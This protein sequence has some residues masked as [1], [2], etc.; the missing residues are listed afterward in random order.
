MAARPHAAGAPP[1]VSPYPSVIADPSCESARDVGRLVRDVLDR[2]GDKWSALI[3][4]MLQ[5]G[6]LRFSELQRRVG[7]ISQRMLTLSLRQLERDGIVTRTVYVQVPLR[8]EYELTP[9][10]STLVPLVLALV[11]WAVEHQ[12]EIKEH[13]D[14][15]DRTHR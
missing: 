4:G 13:R 9:L 12:Q 14:A 11:S 10:G 2:V 5:D 3:I 1:T 8:V 6:P 7:G 15:F